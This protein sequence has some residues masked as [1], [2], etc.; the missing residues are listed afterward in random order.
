MAAGARGREEEHVGLGPEDLAQ[1]A[2]GA[3][4]DARKSG[5]V[6]DDRLG[7]RGE[8]LGRHRRRARR[9][10]VALLRH[11]SRSVAQGVVGT[12]ERISPPGGA[13]AARRPGDPCGARASRSRPA[14][15]ASP[16]DAHGAVRTPSPSSSRPRRGEVPGAFSRQR[17]ERQPE[18]L[19]LLEH[20]LPGSLALVRDADAN[21]NECRPRIWASGIGTSGR[22]SSRY[23]CSLRLIRPVERN[24]VSAS[25]RPSRT[26]YSETCSRSSRSPAAAKR[27]A[28]ERR[29]R[30]LA[31]PPSAWSPR[32]TTAYWP[33]AN[34]RSA[35]A[36]A[37]RGRGRADR[38][39]DCRTR[40]GADERLLRASSTQG[41]DLDVVLRRPGYVRVIAA[42]ARSAVAR[43]RRSRIRL[44][45]EDVVGR[46]RVVATSRRRR[47]RATIG[48]R[49]RA[50][51]RGEP[52]VGGHL[53]ADQAV[54]EPLVPP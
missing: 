17:E 53:H 15:R 11:L 21:A 48:R 12:P 31:Y 47:S 24:T 51:R 25:S 5:P 42:T 40:S 3:L 41:L 38:R 32:S 45:D 46:R 20:V 34:E 4:E 39:R 7:H 26:S 8:H 44:V 23:G 35:C 54:L 2:E 13:R 18:A 28:G 27:R 29:Q 10:Q 6:V 22:R 49:P 1:P 19:G 36:A 50:R 33:S 16:R 52:P 37:A 43:P 9:H 14:S 30:H